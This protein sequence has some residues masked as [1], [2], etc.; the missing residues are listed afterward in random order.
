MLY[1]EVRIVYFWCTLGF[2]KIMYYP[3]LVNKT[4]VFQVYLAMEAGYSEKVDELCDKY[5]LTGFIKAKG[6]LAFIY[7]VILK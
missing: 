4:F 6:M 2:L 1:Y 7:A 5:S 3:V